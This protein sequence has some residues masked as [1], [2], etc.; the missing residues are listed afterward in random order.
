MTSRTWIYQCD[1]LADIGK[2]AQLIVFMMYED[3]KDLRQFLF[4]H[5]NGND[6]NWRHVFNVTEKESLGWENCQPMLSCNDWTGIHC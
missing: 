4:C 5:T 1:E 6:V 3:V 2:E